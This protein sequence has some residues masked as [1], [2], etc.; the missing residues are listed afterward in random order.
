MTSPAFD[1]HWT[2]NKLIEEVL[3]EA[4]TDLKADGSTHATDYAR[5]LGDRI[6]EHRPDVWLINTGW[7]AGAYGQGHRIA[8]PHTR[9][10]IRGV[11]DG[12][13]AG[14]AGIA[15]PIFGLRT[16]QAVPDVPPELLTPRQTWSDPQAYDQQARR[17]AAM[18]RENF[19]RYASEVSSEVQAAAPRS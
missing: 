1:L 17:L 12:S 11:L 3:G 13:L 6:R 16:P 7:T 18:F 5:M 10:M 4:Y 15:D 19:K 8:I 9:A 14:D 2:I